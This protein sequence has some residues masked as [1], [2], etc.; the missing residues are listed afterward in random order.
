M[1]SWGPLNTALPTRRRGEPVN[2]ETPRSR[3]R[4]ACSR[5]PSACAPAGSPPEVSGSFSGA[6]VVPGMLER[7]GSVNE[8]DDGGAGDIVSYDA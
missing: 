6:A 4:R 5:R 1:A 8:A 2:P 3:P 7:S